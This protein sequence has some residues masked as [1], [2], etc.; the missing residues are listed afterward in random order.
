MKKGICENV[1]GIIIGVFLIA[2][3]LVIPFKFLVWDYPI[4]RDV[5]SR[6]D[7]AQIMAESEDMSQMVNEAIIGLEARN[8]I[9]GHCAL[10]FKTPS[11]DLGMQYEA[12][13]NMRERLGRTNTFDKNS[14]Q[15]Q[16][17]ID[18]LRGTIRELNYIDCWI[19]HF[20]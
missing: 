7:R 20:N 6:L 2:V 13:N 8:Q 5:W 11:N 19:W 10:Y 16:S 3:L 1:Q 12:L 15:Y 17:A 4:D 14:V 18:D 9:S